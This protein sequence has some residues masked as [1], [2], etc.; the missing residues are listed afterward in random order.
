VRKWPKHQ[1]IGLAVI[2]VVVVGGF[3]FYSLATRE[4][5]GGSNIYYEV[6]VFSGRPNPGWGEWS[7]DRDPILDLF[8]VERTAGVAATIPDD[9]G[10]RGVVLTS[11]DFPGDDTLD[12][13]RV[14]QNG[15]Y[16]E[17]ADGVVRFVEDSEVW[18]P[19][20]AKLEFSLTSSEWNAVK[21]I[22]GL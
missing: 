2:A 4:S 7:E 18:P 21:G 8:T 14:V 16:L 9:L 15:Y 3:A 6:D 5:N 22:G 12:D 20:R 19:I 11:P 10:F 17:F 1:V 13:V